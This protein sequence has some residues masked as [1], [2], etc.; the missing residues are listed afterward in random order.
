MY[1]LILV[2]GANFRYYDYVLKSLNNITN[3]IEN[4][5]HTNLNI[6]IIFYNLGFTNEQIINLKD[7]FKKVIFKDFNF[8]EYPEHVSL[9][10]YYDL[11]CT[12]AW[13]PI[14]FHK[15]C[16]EYKNIVYWFDTR[17]YFTN[18]RNIINILNESYI[19]SPVSSGNINKWTYPTTFK[20]MDY[21][22][23]YL[24]YQPRAAG[25]IGI[26]YNINWCRD[27][28]T[29]WK[30]LALIK[31]CISPESSDRTNHRQDQSILSILYYKYNDI[32]NFNMINHYIDITPHYYV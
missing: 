22:Y 28:I 14:I 15:V 1:D 20:Y 29:E 18:F 27:L 16:E 8:N 26:N 12:Y 5:N 24:E 4:D 2:G 10:K 30:D 13:K 3:I 21:G 6:I 23:K 11:N 32:Y 19:Y 9:E 31:E 7:T 25:I 17:S